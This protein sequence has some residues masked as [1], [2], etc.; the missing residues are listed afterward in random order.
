LENNEKQGKP[1]GKQGK[2]MKNKDPGFSLFLSVWVACGSRL[3]H[4]QTVSGS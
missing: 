2:T 4:P 1:L 3:G